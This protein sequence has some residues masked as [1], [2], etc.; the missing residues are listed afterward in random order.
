MKL[1][2]L[3]ILT[4]LVVTGCNK[5][6]P[7]P[8]LKDPIYA[9]LNS[10]LGG[11]TAEL[12]AETKTL[13]GHQ[14]EL[15][16][17]VPQTGQIKY[18]QKR[19]FESEAKI[20]RLAQEKKYLELKIEARKS[21]SRK[22]YMTAFKKGETWPDMAEYDAYKAELR[23]RNAKTTWDVKERMKAAGV[24]DSDKPAA[25]EKPAGGGEE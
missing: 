22:S 7:H 1:I 14:A 23:L 11:V 12:N 25:V 4:L 5:P 10:R 2:T 3:I 6:D 19:V 18:A 16:K 8:E 21:E 9:D 20:T 15:A 24:L 17:V 13:E